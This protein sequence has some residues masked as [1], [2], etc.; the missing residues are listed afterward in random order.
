MKSTVIDIESKINFHSEAEIKSLREEN[1]K[2]KLE[3]FKMK[4]EAGERNDPSVIRN[5]SN[6]SDLERHN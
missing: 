5:L 3:N 6:V 4:G 1:S 2:L